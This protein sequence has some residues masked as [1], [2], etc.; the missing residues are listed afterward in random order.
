MTHQEIFNSLDK[1]D[2]IKSQ[3]LFKFYENNKFGKN[4][5][6]SLKDFCKINIQII[7]YAYF[8]R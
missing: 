5:V 1:N 2:Q 7:R 6:V 4:I 8:K 3:N